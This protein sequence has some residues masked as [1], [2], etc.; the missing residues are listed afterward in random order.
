MMNLFPYG[1]ILH[2]LIFFVLGETSATAM[3]PFLSQTRIFAGEDIGNFFKIV[4]ASS[5][6][7][8]FSKINR[9]KI[10]H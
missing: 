2:F 4:T 9:I 8:H 6:V 5:V 1:V 10:M 3:F 7:L